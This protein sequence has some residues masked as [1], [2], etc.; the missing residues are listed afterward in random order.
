MG[1]GLVEQGRSFEKI[2][3]CPSLMVM[4]PASMEYMTSET[5]LQECFNERYQDLDIHA[6]AEE[7]YK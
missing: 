2:A 4:K 3:T 6:I 7:T 5:S 1:G